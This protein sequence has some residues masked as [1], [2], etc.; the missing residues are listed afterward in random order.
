MNNAV[1][2]SLKTATSDLF[3]MDFS[4]IRPFGIVVSVLDCNIVMI[5]NPD[6]TITFTFGLMPKRK[7]WT[8]YPSSSGF[9]SITTVQQEWIWY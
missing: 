6:W 3:A 7:V 4:P 2:V 5:L 1:A 9:N 8:P